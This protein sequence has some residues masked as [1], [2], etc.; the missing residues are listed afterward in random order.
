MTE[1][2]FFTGACRFQRW[3]IQQRSRRSGGPGGLAPLVAPGA[4]APL[5][6]RKG[7]KR[8]RITVLTYPPKMSFSRALFEEIEM[9]K[10][11]TDIDRPDIQSL[12]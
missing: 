4:I 10:V 7:T 2:V 1:R 3:I 5:A 12:Q 8:S 9:I 6:P 11:F